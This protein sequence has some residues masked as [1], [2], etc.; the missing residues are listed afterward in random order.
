M[1]LL[2]YEKKDTK[3]GV[4]FYTTEKYDSRQLLGDLGAKGTKNFVSFEVENKSL[5]EV[6]SEVIDEIRFKLS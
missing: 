2:I 4:E 6:E 3:I 1:V 5:N